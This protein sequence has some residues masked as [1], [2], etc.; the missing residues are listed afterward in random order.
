MG[1]VCR[2]SVRSAA[3]RFNKTMRHTVC[4]VVTVVL[5]LL[6]FFGFFGC[7]GSGKYTSDDV[8]LINTAYYGSGKNP[9]YSFAL[10]KEEDRW[11]FSADCLV[12]NQKE[13]Y[14]SFGSFPITAE[15]AEAFLRIICEDGEIERLCKYRNPMRFFHISDVPARTF[16]MTF[17]DGNTIE[18]E[19]MLGDRA[20]NYLYALAGRYY[21]A[22]ESSADTPTVGV[23]Q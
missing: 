15:D 19:T 10:K 3:D 13:H 23:Q 4:N 11:F 8:V 16:G 2:N 17:S 5:A 14:T 18:K 22:A 7:S 9:V 12:G 20:L 1:R 6:S 21:E